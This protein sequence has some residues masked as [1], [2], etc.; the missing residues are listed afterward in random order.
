LS[1]QMGL[2]ECCSQPG[3]HAF[4][5]LFVHLNG[6][7]YLVPWLSGTRTATLG[8]VDGGLWLA[9]GSA[10]SSGRVGVGCEI[11]R[12]S[13]GFNDDLPGGDGLWLPGGRG[14][15]QVPQMRLPCGFGVLALPCRGYRMLLA[16]ARARADVCRTWPLAC[17]LVWPSAEPCPGRRGFASAVA[18]RGWLGC[19]CNPFVER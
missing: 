13:S 5:R 11:L 8:S 18:N 9:A 10:F 16:W 14:C 7:T 4:V 2:C 17:G 15:V 3:Q 19:V 1:G 6:A 12:S